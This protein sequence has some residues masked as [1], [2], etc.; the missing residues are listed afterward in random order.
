MT[1]ER[2]LRLEEWQYTM[3]YVRLGK[4]VAL[5]LPQW[6]DLEHAPRPEKEIRERYEKNQKT[7]FIWESMILHE[8]EY[9]FPYLSGE[10]RWVAGEE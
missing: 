6:E 2:M 8:M 7:M 9:D 4:S 3:I 1:E 10:E 5:N